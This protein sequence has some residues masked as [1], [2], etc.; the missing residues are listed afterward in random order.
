MVLIT[1][2]PNIVSHASASLNSA[3]SKPLNWKLES[4]Y[5]VE[6]FFKI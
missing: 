6:R 1:G 3:L 5:Y 4:I 2:N